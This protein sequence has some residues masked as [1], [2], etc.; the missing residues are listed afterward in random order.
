MCRF[1]RSLVLVAHRA[2][3]V[4][5]NLDFTL[6]GRRDVGPLSRFVRPR[7]FQPVVEVE[8]LC[9]FIK[10]NFVLDFFKLQ[11]A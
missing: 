2:F 6:D 3:S 10:V 1:A 9:L 5:L 7:C 8:D 11:N 4:G